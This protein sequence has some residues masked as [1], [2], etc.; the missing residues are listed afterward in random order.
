MP[1]LASTGRIISDLA[2]LGR[3][4]SDL[5]LSDRVISDLV[6]NWSETE[7]NFDHDLESRTYLNEKFSALFIYEVKNMGS[8]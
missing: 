7:Q 1:D 4:I 2:L 6:L 3:V 5:A 8:R